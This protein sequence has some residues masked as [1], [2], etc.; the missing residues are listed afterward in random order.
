M[1]VQFYVVPRGNGMVT[2]P[3][4]VSSRYDLTNPRDR[5]R[6]VMAAIKFYQLLR[7]QMALYPVDVLPAGA[8]ERADGLGFTREL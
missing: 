7:A 3:R 4:A 8:V 1:E 6:A 5:V 2:A